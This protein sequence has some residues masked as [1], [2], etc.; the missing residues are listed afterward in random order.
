MAFYSKIAKQ[1]TFK[2]QVY[3]LYT[4]SH[5]TEQTYLKMTMFLLSNT[6]PYREIKL[7]EDW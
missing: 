1:T 2:I 6:K 5:M 7:F 3:T 4:H